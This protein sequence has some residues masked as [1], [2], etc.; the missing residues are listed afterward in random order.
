[1]AVLEPTNLLLL[2]CALIYLWIGEPAE[3]AILLV[4]VAAISGLDALQQRRSRRALAELT[5]LAAPAVRLQR[6]GEELSLPPDQVQCGD[7]LRLEAGDRVAADARITEAAGLWLDESLLTG[8]AL[9]VLRQGQGEAIQAGALVASGW[10][11]AEVVATGVNTEL[12]RIGAS[13][14][15]VQPPLTRLQRQTRRLTARLTTAA[16]AGTTALLLIHGA[17][18]GRWSE[19]L[20]AA[21]A[22]ALAVLP[23]EIPVVLAL[24]LALGAV[25]LGRI[26]VLARWP[27]AVESLGGTTV[28]AVDKTGTLT[29]NRMAV[30][31]LLTW[32][33]ADSW[34]PHLA[35]AEPWH[36]VLE[37]AVLASRSDPV[38]AMEVAIQQL[39]EERLEGEHRD[40]L[41]PDWPLV[42]DYPITPEL[43]VVSKLWSDSDGRQHIAAKGA[44]EAIAALCHLEREGAAR[45]LQAAEELS[46]EGLRVL[47]VASGLDGAPR[48]H[49]LDG[50]D[51][52]PL[53]ANVHDFLFEPIGLVALVDPLRPEVPEAIAR[54]QAAGVRV[55]MIS[56]DA[57]ATARSIADQ[58]GLPPGD[59]I[60]G[61]ELEQ[62]DPRQLAQRVQSAAVFARVMPQQKLQLVRALQ[63][64]GEVVAMGGDGV[65]DAPAL[66]AADIGVAMGKR[67]TA[68]AREAADLVL[69][70]DDFSALV[71]ALGLGRRIEANLHKALGYTLAIHL[72]IALLSLLPLLVPQ[73]PLLLLPVH[74]ALLHLVI[75]PACTVVFEGMEG[76][77]Q[78]MEQPPRAADAPLFAAHTWHASLRQG[79]LLSAMVLLASFWPDLALSERRSW[80]FALLLIGGGALVWWNGDRRS[81]ITRA[82]ALI[83]V[84]LWLL[85]QAIPGLVN[86]LQLVPTPPAMALAVMVAA[87]ALLLMAGQSSSPAVP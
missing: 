46:A 41:H 34:R 17:T 62:L 29:Q 22:L 63:A 77:P 14:S 16:L 47:A 80:V 45:L 57:P 35:L 56:G 69:L 87:L 43:L 55:V 53:T 75:D 1:M 8:E 70:R 44:P 79:A 19:A 42:R 50:S 28:L 64:A 59:P 5:R 18:T 6:H 13:L 10:G 83:G 39:A 67:G 72:P 23:N 82:G 49:E 15:Q 7:L 52:E 60:C 3:A 74:I 36:R 32:P 65:N 81:G 33:E 4:F 25:R 54:A 40:H 85:V 78:L 9:P 26:G 2:A 84:G 48:H 21:L 68:V 66:K 86:L 51:Q 31:A 71:E 20:L 11:W 38:D 58:A 73:F 27:A 12:G 24:F 76:S 30:A 37:F 61:A